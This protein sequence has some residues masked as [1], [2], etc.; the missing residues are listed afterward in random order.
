[1]IDKGFDNTTLSLC[2]WRYSPIRQHKWWMDAPH[3][4]D[5]EPLCSLG[6]VNWG[7]CWRFIQHKPEPARCC[8]NMAPQEHSE[9]VAPWFLG[10]IRIIA[11]LWSTEICQYDDE[12]H[13]WRRRWW[14]GQCQSW[15]NVGW[16]LTSHINSGLIAQ[17]KEL[18]S[19]Y[20]TGSNRVLPPHAKQMLFVS[21]WC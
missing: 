19:L 12:D 17:K 5:Q 20:L 6:G 8:S 14:W 16:N 9:E 15:I 1:M 11:F 3:P 13:W 10:G 4:Q 2:W 7:R 21:T 18:Q